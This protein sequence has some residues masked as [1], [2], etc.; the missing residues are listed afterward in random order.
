MNIK[1]AVEIIRTSTVIAI[2]RKVPFEKA[3]SVS[4]AVV[5]GGVS[6]IEVTMDGADAAQ[7]IKELRKEHEGKILIGAG[8]IMTSEQIHLA[9]NA[10]ADVLFCP[11]LDVQLLQEAKRLGTLLIPG[12]TTP[13]EVAVAKQA[14]AEVLKLFPA[15]SLG[16]GYLKALLGPFAG[17]LFIPTGG[18][19]PENAA[20]YLKAGAVAVGMGSAL[21]P[22]SEVDKGDFAAISN[23]IKTVMTSLQAK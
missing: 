5:N 18:I 17:T 8:T 11:H 7:I 16:P 13:T 4:S 15:G 19:S 1:N 6:A 23:Q 9:L 21:F 20:S 2:L 12:V 10:G 14:G 22:K 3:I